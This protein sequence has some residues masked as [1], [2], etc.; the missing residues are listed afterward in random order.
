[1]CSLSSRSRYYCFF[2]GLKFLGCAWFE[3]N[4][5]RFQRKQALSTYSNASRFEHVTVSIWLLLQLANESTALGIGNEVTLVVASSGA[6]SRGRG[7]I[8]RRAGADVAVTE[9]DW[10]NYFTEKSAGARCI[11]EFNLDYLSRRLYWRVGASEHIL[12]HEILVSINTWQSVE[13]SKIR[14]NFK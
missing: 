1:M 6:K 9:T 8:D 12:C 4:A 13:M 3:P 11:I 7:G 2:L 10:W 14:L 5:L